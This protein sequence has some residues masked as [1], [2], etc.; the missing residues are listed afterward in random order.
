MRSADLYVRRASSV[1]FMALQVCSIGTA[2]AGGPLY[3]VPSGGTL[4][5]ARWEGTV[6]V[7]TDQGSLGALDNEQANQLV[8]NSVA[9]W[10]SVSTSSFRAAVVGSLPHD[11]TGAN[12]GEVIGVAN[13]GGIQ[14]IYD[15]DGSVIADFI[16]AGYG[17]LGIATPEFLAGEGSTQIVEGWVII[18][19]ETNYADWGYPDYVP[20]E[21]TSGVVT[22][23]FGHAINLAHSQTNGYYSRNRPDPDFGLPAGPEQAGP[24]QCGAVVAEYP[25]ADQIETMY[26]LINPFPFRT[27]YNSPADG[28]RKR[29]G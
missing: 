14:V 28:D 5:P 19:G 2:M 6:K 8:R 9:Q 10:S 24:D 20:G 11:I 29:I 7:Y 12:A 16:G 26:P 17:V 3:V 22:H 21:P 4:Q 27:G 13:G 23:E 1:A 15:N 18:S 25:T